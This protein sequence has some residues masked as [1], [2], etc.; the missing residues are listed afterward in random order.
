MHLV[1]GD[2]DEVK[3]KGLEITAGVKYRAQIEIEIDFENE[4]RSKS[5]HLIVSK[6]LVFFVESSTMMERSICTWRL[7][8]VK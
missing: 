2:F 8:N 3:R 6:D 5:S 4:S 7:E 1:F